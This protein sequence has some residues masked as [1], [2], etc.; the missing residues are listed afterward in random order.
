MTLL[1]INEVVAMLPVSRA[2]FFRVTRHD[3]TFPAP[4]PVGAR[5]VWRAGDVEAWLRTSDVSTI[6]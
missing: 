5:S 6:R 4:V 3:P 1:T 2:T